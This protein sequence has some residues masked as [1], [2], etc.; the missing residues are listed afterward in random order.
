MAETTLASRTSLTPSRVRGG[1]RRRDGGRGDGGGGGGGGG[2][3]E[4]IEVEVS[5]WRKCWGVG[6][7]KREWK[8]RVE[9]ESGKK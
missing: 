5:R 9:R 2:E 6:G 1:E 4:G 8:G 7:G 3:R